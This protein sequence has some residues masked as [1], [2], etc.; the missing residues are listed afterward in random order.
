MTKKLQEI[1]TVNA[2]IAIAEQEILE[3]TGVSMR[4]IVVSHLPELVQKNTN[5]PEGL[6]KVVADAL[7]MDYQHYGSTSRKEA[8]VHLKQLGC[9]FLKQYMGDRMTLK[10]IGEIIG[11]Y[12]HTCVLYS[13]RTVEHKLFNNDKVYVA[14]HGICLEAITQWMND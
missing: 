10:A 12:D 1:N 13:I 2:I 8:F 9:Y 14:K 6:L 3:R 4:L 5:S 7:E 11:N